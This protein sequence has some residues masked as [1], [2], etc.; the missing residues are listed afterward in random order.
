MRFVDNLLPT[1][2]ARE[3]LA[4]SLYHPYATIMRSMRVR[5]PFWLFPEL[6]PTGAY[7]S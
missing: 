7:R 3:M 2:A 6:Q 4:I 5:V 1:L